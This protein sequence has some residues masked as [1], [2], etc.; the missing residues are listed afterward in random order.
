MTWLLVVAMVGAWIAQWRLDGEDLAAVQRT[1]GLCPATVVAAFEEAGALGFGVKL[2]ARLDDL[3]L[4]AVLPFF[5]YSLLH[6]GVVHALVNAVVLR[7]VGA[8]LEAR[9]AAARWAVFYFAAAVAAGV[10]Q[11]ALHPGAEMPAMGASGPVAAAVAAWI[12][13]HPRARVVV[14]VPV[15]L[16]PVTAQLPGVF[17]A[18][19]WAALQVRPVRML[20]A[21]G[22]GEPLDWA[23]LA[24]SAA[25]GLALAPWLLRPRRG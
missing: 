15:L 13:C 23:A 12:C 1:L 9:A 16:V 21:L 2:L 19:G 10:A 22:Q 17:L 24:V 7:V 6:A 11:V 18:L 8:R 14:A 25:V 20:L 3:A 5:T 4:R